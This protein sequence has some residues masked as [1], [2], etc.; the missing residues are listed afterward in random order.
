MKTAAMIMARMGS[1]RLPGKVLMNLNNKPALQHVIERCKR[2][3]NNVIVVCTDDKK[4]LEIIEF[5][6]LNN[7][8]YF[9]GKGSDVIKQMLDA[10]E[11]FK[12]GLIVD[13]TADCPLVDSKHIDILIKN[14]FKKKVLYTSNLLPRTFPDGFDIQVYKTE[15]L[16]VIDHIISE[17]NIQAR[18]NTGWNIAKLADKRDIWTLITRDKRSKPEMRLTLDTKEED[19]IM[20]LLLSRDGITLYSKNFLS[21][22]E[23][24]ESLF[25]GFI[26]AMNSFLRETL[27]ESGFIERIKYKDY[28]VAIQNIDPLMFCYFYKGQ[29]YFALKK[30]QNFISDFLN[31]EQFLS[32]KKPE[33]RYENI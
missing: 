30:I 26:S 31:S 2:S 32:V 29:S 20:F 12:I 6:I 13:V 21:E 3:V 28:H 23:Y 15:T 8:K 18:R 1:T 11:K 9:V 22:S 7:Y 16:S 14:F 4:D 5:C 17:H 27:S 19:P 33:V 10:A 25:A 24:D